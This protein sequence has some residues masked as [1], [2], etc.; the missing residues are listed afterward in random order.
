[1]MLSALAFFGSTPTQAG[2]SDRGWRKKGLQ[3]VV[4][5]LPP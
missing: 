4:I 3:M 1:M 5:G 2:D